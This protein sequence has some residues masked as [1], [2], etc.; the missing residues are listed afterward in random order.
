MG[1]KPTAA[2]ANFKDEKLHEAARSGD[3]EAVQAVCSA[4]PLAVDS[5]DRHSRTPLHLAAWSGHAEVVN[6]LCNNK[7]DIGAA[8][9][10]DMG[11][12]HFAA[13]K[14]HLEVVK[15]LHTSGVSIKSYNR[16]GMTA[17]HYAAQGSH[18]ELV[19]YLVKKGANLDAKNKA[20]KTAVDFASSEEVQ[21]FLMEWKNVSGKSVGV[22]GEKREKGEQE[23]AHEET[24]ESVDDALDGDKIA[25]DDLDGDKIA[26]DENDETLKRKGVEET[27]EN[28]QEAKKS[29]VSLNHLLAADD[30]QEEEEDM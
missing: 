27:R 24:T 7:A 21:S 3:I 26:E 15:I 23:S 19:K 25:E 8:A 28:Q 16:K 4:N 6:Y 20:G 30:T 2:D 10:D 11:A 17:L 22:G 5:R 12:I 13:Q 9:M 29:K 1:K 18:L 14:G